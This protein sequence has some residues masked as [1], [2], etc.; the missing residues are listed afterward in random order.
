MLILKYFP[1]SPEGIPVAQGQL[2]LGPVSLTG[3]E[4]TCGAPE[5]SLF[6]A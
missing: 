2:F 3:S 6:C 1:D 5:T 4:K